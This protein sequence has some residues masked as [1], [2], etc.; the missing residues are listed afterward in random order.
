M[1]LFTSSD[2][3]I[4]QTWGQGILQRSLLLLQ[5]FP[6]ALPFRRKSMSGRR[7]RVETGGN[8]CRTAATYFRGGWQR[9]LFSF[10]KAEESRAGNWVLRVQDYK[11][12]F[13]KTNHTFTSCLKKYTDLYCSHVLG[14]PNCCQCDC[15]VVTRLLGELCSHHRTMG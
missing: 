12:S 6:S 9:G 4:L 13:W 10:G 3:T 8:T 1:Q 14:I 11:M 5:N 7:K 15:G 2:P